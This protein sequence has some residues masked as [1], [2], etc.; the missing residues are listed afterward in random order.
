MLPPRLG[1][2]LPTFE[3]SEP[4]G[5]GWSR[6][7]VFRDTLRW[8]EMLAHARLIEESGFDSLWVPDHLLFRWDG[9]RG[10]SQGAWD[11]WS[12]LAAL[13]AATA[14]V[15]LGTLVLCT[16]FRNPALLAKMA[17]TVD[18]ISGG[19]LILGLGAGYHEPEFTAF[20]YPFNHRGARFEEAVTVITSLLR[21]GTV[22][23]E[24]AYVSAP[25]C[26]LRPRGP[27]P[28]GPP[29]MLGGGDN[30]GARTLRLGAEHA[31][32]WDTWLAFGRSHPDAIVPRL[33]QVD[34]ACGDIDR[35][36]ATLRRS[37]TIMVV[38]PGHEPAATQ[39]GMEP[40]TGT[41]AEI[42]ETF[43]DFGRL[44]VANL[45]LVLNPFSASAIEALAPVVRALSVD[46]LQAGDESPHTRTNIDV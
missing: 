37:A 14:R 33:R 19:R 29:I 24:G 31:D 34:A 40:V 17:D 16:A 27:R 21:D 15:E 22:D 3:G 13:A 36:P 39:P 23:F 42:A 35:E 26:E 9:E 41:A 20:G 12:I 38:A 1:I 18:E 2:F 11:G 5:P 45:Q 8:P 30:P 32:L 10:P 4:S 6:N 28:E 46:T 7:G 43:R 25:T 44:G